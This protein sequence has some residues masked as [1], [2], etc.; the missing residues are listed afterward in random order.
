MGKGKKGYIHDSAV[1]VAEFFEAEE[2]GAMSGVVEGK[3]LGSM[4]DLSLEP[5]V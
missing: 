1:D 4:S 3:A 5:S 2:S